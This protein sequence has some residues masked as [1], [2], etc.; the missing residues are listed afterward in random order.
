MS[1]GMMPSKGLLHCLERLGKEVAKGKRI[2]NAALKSEFA[3]LSVRLERNPF[4][5]DLQ[6]QVASV[7]Y[8]LQK[9]EV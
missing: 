6:A 3:K 7:R 4:D 5:L 8:E 9:A 2:S 1:G